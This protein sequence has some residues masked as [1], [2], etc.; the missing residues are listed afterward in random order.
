MP[1]FIWKSAYEIKI[2]EIDLDHRHLVG[3]IND[4]YEQMKTGHGYELIDEVIDQL[5]D[6]VG[7]HFDREE[8]FMRAG[9][10][11]A[12]TDH[13]AEHERF[14]AHILEMD[15]RRRSGVSP[16]AIEL[17]NYL[18]DWLRDHVST[19]DK[20]MGQYLRRVAD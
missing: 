9:S 6:Y 17:L 19:A 15:A 20:K 12:M 3:L 14:R 4:L 11:P 16:T 2:P 18:S 10:Y 13:L 7:S 8:G 1:L 5:I